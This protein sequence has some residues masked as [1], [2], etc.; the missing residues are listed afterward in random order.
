MRGIVL[1][2]LLVNLVY[3]GWQFLLPQDTGVAVSAR[4]SP[5]VEGVSS[6]ELL[7]EVD[8]E[9]LLRYPVAV[10]AP[11]FC[12]EIGPFADRQDAEGFMVTNAERFTMQQEV[13]QVA[14]PS[15]YR[16]FLPPFTSRELADSTMAALRAAF[17]ANNMQIDS[18]LVTQGELANGIALGLFTDH[19]NALNVQSQLQTLGYSV[20]VREE[21]RISEEIWVLVSG[22]ASEADFMSHWTEIQLSRSYIRA[23]EKLC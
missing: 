19:R 4:V 1:G 9:R 8:A 13:R 22:L 18:F 11:E 20:V 15:I 23:G 12:A 10:T 17:V 6:I 3:F 16:V 5:I 21:P 2:L 14:A 7:S